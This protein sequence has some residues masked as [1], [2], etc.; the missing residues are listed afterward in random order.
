[1]PQDA[2]RDARAGAAIFNLPNQLTSLRLVL[3]IVLF[4]FMACGWFWI[5]FWLFLVAAGTDW[6]DGYFA[7][8]YGLVT[9]LGRI[10]DPFADKVIICG[11]FIL[12]AAVSRLTE[13]PWGLQAWMVVVIVGRELLVTALRSFIEERGGDF[14][15]RMSGKWKMLLQCVAAAACLLWLSY[16]PTKQPAPEWIRWVLIASVWSSLV[17]TIYSGAVYVRAAARRLG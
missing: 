4:G 10:L 8:K 5:G 11:T 1:M 12:L 7:R 6:F 9:T 17:L 13:M 14:S 2:Q 15:A 3:A 16:D